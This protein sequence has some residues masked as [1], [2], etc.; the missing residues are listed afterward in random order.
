MKIMEQCA[1]ITCR[2]GKQYK[3][4]SSYKKH[5]LSCI[6][7]PKGQPLVVVAVE[8]KQI[9]HPSPVHA[10][11]VSASNQPYS[12]IKEKC[13]FCQL[14]I[15]SPRLKNHISNIC[16]QR[17]KNTPEYIEL[18]KLGLITPGL[19]NKEIWAMC[20]VIKYLSATGQFNSAQI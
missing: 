4:F 12:F 8:Q 1:V 20:R 13:P 11:V 19:T 2:C 6:S 3:H 16:Q 5:F 17:F 10:A 15:N 14:K 9:N 7:N 18:S